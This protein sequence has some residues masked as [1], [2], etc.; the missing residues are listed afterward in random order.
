MTERCLHCAI[1]AAI[2]AHAEEHLPRDPSGAVRVECGLALTALA[3]AVADLV[4]LPDDE[5]ARTAAFNCFMTALS[6]AATRRG[7]PTGFTI[8]EASAPAP[9]KGLH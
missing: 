5:D 2:E 8:T 9:H 3:A 7:L 6:D 1:R 4:T